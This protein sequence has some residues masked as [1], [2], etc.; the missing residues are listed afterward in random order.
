MTGINDSCNTDSASGTDRPFPD[1]QTNNNV[2]VPLLNIEIN[3]TTMNRLRQRFDPFEDDGNHG[4]DLF[5]NILNFLQ[6]QS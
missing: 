4:I 3:E 2:V 5:C 6:R 1:L